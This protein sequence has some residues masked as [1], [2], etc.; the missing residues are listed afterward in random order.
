MEISAEMVKSLREKT[1]AGMMK[2]KEALIACNGNTEEAIDYLRKKGLASADGK[3][4][5]AAS[6]GLIASSLSED[7]RVASIIEVNCET[8]FVARN[9]NF[10]NFVTTLSDF[11]LREKNIKDV[12]GLSNA[13]LPS[14]QAVDETRKAL[15]AK[16]GE[17][18]VIGRCERLEIPSGKH[19]VID[20]YIHGEGTLGVLV[21][22][23]CSDATAA[24]HDDLK[25]FAH[26]IALQVAA[27]KPWFVTR[28]DVPQAVLNREKD[29]ILGQIKNDPKNA[30][31]PDNILEK[32]VTGR[33]DKFYKERC[34]IEQTSIRDENMTISKLLGD[35]S[36][37]LG[38]EVKITG[39]RR[40]AVG[41]AGKA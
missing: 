2:C 10:R 25:S 18:I 14:G 39:F 21:S 20:A 24:K 7:K 36:K 28:N 41:E 6:Q 32:I 34:L 37:K 31:K 4:G 22:V 8:D 30:N 23:E 35:I 33:L 13:T 19:G 15:I 27:M 9:E 40:W 16:I 17:N 3:A 1:G 11:L 29:V 26:E 5:R 38:C 12:E